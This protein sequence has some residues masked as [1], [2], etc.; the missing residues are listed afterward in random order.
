MVSK[1]IILSANALTQNDGIA[2]SRGEQEKSGVN[3]SFSSSPWKCIYWPCLLILKSKVFLFMR[4]GAFEI[5]YRL[6]TH[7]LLL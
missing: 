1:V 7:G 4:H 6:Q 2:F 5:F 3:L